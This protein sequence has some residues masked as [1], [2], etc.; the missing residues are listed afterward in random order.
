MLLLATEKDIDIIMEIISDAKVY[1]K[2]Q[3]LKQWN[4]DDGY[5]RKEDLLNDINNKSCFLYTEEDLVIGCM[6]ILFTPD[7]NYEDINGKWLS[8]TKYASIHR[9]AIKNNYHHKGIGVKMLLEAETIVKNN[10]VFFIKIDTHKDNIPM[11]K[12]IL[13]SGYS[14]CGIIKLKRSETDNLRDAYE[15]GLLR[16]K[17][18]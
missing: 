7:E 16:I 2:N 8:N 11:T 15:K 13:S 3:N 4:L 14:Y 18:S 9:I 10:N 1:L 17:I 5:P 12:T 6:S